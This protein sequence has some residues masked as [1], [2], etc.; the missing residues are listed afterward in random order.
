MEDKE[1]IIGEIGNDYIIIK[2]L[3]YGGQAN[4]FLV[5]D[6][7]TN[8]KYA[9]KV[10]KYDNSSF[11][12]D[13][14]KIL[15]TL[16]NS[17]NIINYIEYKEGIIKRN[18]REPEKKNYLI[19]ELSYNRSLDEYIRFLPNGFKEEYCKIIFYRIAKCVK[20]IHDKGISHR[21]IKP[22][23]ILLDKDFHPKITDFGH[24]IKYSSKLTGTAGTAR[25]KA[26]ELIND[27]AEK[28]YD[29][30]KIDIFSLGVTLFELRFR[31]ILFQ[32]ATLEEYT[33]KI[34]NS[35]DL[36]KTK[37]ALW[38]LIESKPSFGGI[39]DDFKDLYTKMISFDPDKRPTIDEILKHKWFGNIRN[40]TEEELNKYEEEIKIRQEFEKRKIEVDKKCKNEI[41]NDNDESDVNY[42][43]THPKKSTS[44]DN[45]EF[46]KEVPTIKNVELG[47]YMNYYINIKG[48]LNP[49]KFM[50]SLCKEIINEFGNDNCYIKADKNNKAQIDII[51]EEDEIPNE[52]KEKLKDI[53]IKIN[54]ATKEIEMKIKL[55]KTTEGYLLRFVR[56]NGEK[57]DFIDKFEKLS[58]LV[59]NL[60]K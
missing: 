4:V 27:E 30:Y 7:K 46:F 59:K 6:K 44:D 17:Q 50:N 31:I 21:D 14:Y 22:D 41:E 56:K 40:M 45:N 34:L 37:E 10:P 54:E 43:I 60:F 29:G 11:L 58:K 18:G 47:K 23:N 2:K 48:F 25:Y 3:S 33:Y 13:E 32:E 9:A 35:E 12:E 20:E 24:A 28:G 38:K 39:S 53:G 1:E 55:Y 42:Q 5:K 49:R 8:I 15:D 57:I 36:T 19:L 26:P 51:F 16:K 52:F